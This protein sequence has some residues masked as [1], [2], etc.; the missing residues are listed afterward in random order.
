MLISTENILI[1]IHYA[2][3][4]LYYY[5]FVLSWCLPFGNE[6]RY[7]ESCCNTTMQTVNSFESRAILRD[8][9][10]QV[11]ESLQRPCILTLWY[12]PYI[13]LSSHLPRAQSER[14][15]GR[16]SHRLSSG[17]RPTLATTSAAPLADAA[18]ASATTFSATCWTPPFS[19]PSAFASLKKHSRRDVH[20]RCCRAKSFHY[21]I[22]RHL[23]RI[24]QFDKQ[25][26]L[27]LA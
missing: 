24:L 6:D 15:P 21:T 11:Q 2:V 25:L 5:V 4:P 23:Q 18:P 7:V 8:R 3:Q 10:R 27:C 22:R 26:C 9:P 14:L 19:V 16:L 12:D 1:Y 20:S 13:V 17:S